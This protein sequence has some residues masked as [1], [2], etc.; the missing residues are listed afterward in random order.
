MKNTSTCHRSGFTLPELL[1]TMGI[2][3]VVTGCTI[4]FF[5]YALNIFRYDAA[6]NLVNRDIRKFTS[7]LTDHATDA[8]YF[9][10]YASF[11][12]RST[13]SGTT[14]VSTN[15]E[16]GKTG[17]MLVLVF[18]HPTNVDTITRI[19][20]YYRAPTDVND[21]ASEGPVRKFDL[22]Y[23]PAIDAK[24]AIYTLLPASSTYA[25]NPEVI[26]LSKGLASGR[27][28]Y[29]VGGK[30]IMVNGEIIHRGGQGGTR[31][32]RATNTYN[33]TISPRG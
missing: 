23:N 33:F 32:E 28:F 22:R 9:H 17:D 31:Y 30:S 1:I 5:M 29:N 16:F 18:K 13:T 6:K 4:V 27:L 19:V 8:N 11:S 15:L 7:E 2:S 20:G 12:N 26:E 14:T 10:V 3:V 25:T 24:T 21:P